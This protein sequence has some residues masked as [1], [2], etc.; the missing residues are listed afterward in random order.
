MNTVRN[1]GRIGEKRI[2]RL[3]PVYL[4]SNYE[5]ITIFMRNAIYTFILKSMKPFFVPLL[6]GWNRYNENLIEEVNAIRRC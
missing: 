1:F 2:W 4:A 3:L 6:G 5:R